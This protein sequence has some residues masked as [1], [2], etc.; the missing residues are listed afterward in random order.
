M[1]YFK[2]LFRYI[3]TRV[4]Y[5]GR[6]RLSFSTII[7]RHASFEGH[8]KIGA[9]S[10]FT[11]SMGR[12]SYIGSECDLFA[13][14]GRYTSIGNQ[15]KSIMF[16]H[17]TTYPYVSTSPVFYAPHTPVG[18]GFASRACFKE[19]VMADEATRSAVVIGHDCWIN[20][21]VTLV[22]GITIGDGAVVLTGAV[23]T[24]DVPPYAVVA[25]VPARVIRY[26]YEERH[27]QWLRKV[28]WW[29][30]PVEWL[31]RHW[32]VM[33]DFEQFMQACDKQ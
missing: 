2:Q 15:V 5:R 3:Y 22:S 24:K 4:K 30:K 19:C 10:R 13:T 9:M 29:N 12:Y 25:G 33:T 18:R 7:G 23:V 26:R 8:D 17:P 14:V 16:R 31:E 11:G 20:S 27:I 21:H 28:A 32:E 6:V 1:N